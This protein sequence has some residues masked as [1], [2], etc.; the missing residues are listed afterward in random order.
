MAEKTIAQMTAAAPGWVAEYE[1]S[2]ENNR[3]TLVQIPI[4]CWVVRQTEQ[5]EQVMGMIPFGGRLVY[6][7]QYPLLVKDNKKREFLRMYVQR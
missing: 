2:E 4:A 1:V 6:C 3:P 5:G 7:Q